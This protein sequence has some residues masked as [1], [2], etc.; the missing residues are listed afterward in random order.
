MKS[1]MTY[2]EKSW[3]KTRSYSVEGNT[4]HLLV[5]KT[6]GGSSKV[7][8]ALQRI[9]PE[10]DVHFLRDDT[11]QGLVGLPGLIVFMFGAFLGTTIYEKSPVA[12]YA[13][14][15]AG[16][17][18]MIGGFVL[19]GRIKVYLFKTHEEMGLFEVTGRGNQDEA[20]EHFVSELKQRIGETQA[21][22]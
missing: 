12:F 20:F 17:G 10:P 13:I 7:S 8:I 21:S 3:G 1:A 9:K 19:G 15:A 5:R 11:R 22:R 6:L 14:L 4:L 18:A 2:T 16:L